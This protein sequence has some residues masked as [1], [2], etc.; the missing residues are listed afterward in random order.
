MAFP[1]EELLGVMEWKFDI[2]GVR[3]VDLHI[4]GTLVAVTDAYLVLS[5]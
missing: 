3:G 1:Q 5:L 2:I 4:I